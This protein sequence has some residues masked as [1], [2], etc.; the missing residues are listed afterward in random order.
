MELKEGN[1]IDFDRWSENNLRR[2]EQDILR[3]GGRD[4][5]RLTDT[6]AD[7][8]VMLRALALATIEENRDWQ[9]AEMRRRKNRHRRLALQ[10]EMLAR[11]SE[12]FCKDH[13][14]AVHFWTY[15]VGG[16]SLFGMKDPK[17][18]VDSSSVMAL[19]F[20]S[21]RFLAKQMRE[22]AA[23]FGRFTRRLG[24]TDIGVVHVV[25]RYALFCPRM[26]QLDAL[27]RL[28]TDAFEVTGRDKT[29]SADGLR[30][31]F[32]RHGRRLLAFAIYSA[33]KEEA[34]AKEPVYP[35]TNLGLQPL[36]ES[37]QA[38]ASSDNST[39]HEPSK[40]SDTSNQ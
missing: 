35:V 12:D 14:S 32:K 36:G 23:R 18:L 21:M 15:F 30:Q 7:R 11:D 31:T 38:Q 3:K 20:S 5:K 19:T 22:E 17:P 37:A 4:L 13:M 29:F 24:T 26:E 16:Y 28:L 10:L 6:G 27:A 9:K 25:I 1:G 2:I 34:R 33:R 40:L 8:G 39:I